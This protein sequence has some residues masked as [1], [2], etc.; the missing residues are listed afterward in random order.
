MGFR[1][2]EVEIELRLAGKVDVQPQSAVE[3]EAKR[4]VT[5]AGSFGNSALKADLAVEK[6][7]A[8]ARG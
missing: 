6:P 1:F 2:V 5:K 3:T 7:G 4:S 8:M